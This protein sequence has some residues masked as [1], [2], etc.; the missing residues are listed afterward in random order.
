MKR[1]WAVI[2]KL[3]MQL[4][5]LRDEGSQLDS[6][7]IAGVD[8]ECAC[9][10]M[11]LLIVAGLAV[12]GCPHRLT[13]HGYLLRMTRQGLELLERMRRENV[14]AQPLRRD[15]PACDIELRVREPGAA[16]RHADPCPRPGTRAVE[17]AARAAGP[18]CARRSPRPAPRPAAGNE[19]RHRPSPPQ[20]PPPTGGRPA[21]AAARRCRR[22]GAGQ[23]VRGRG[24]HPTFTGTSVIV[25][26]PKR[27]ITFT[28]TV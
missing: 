6:D 26:L 1:E 20:G 12:G 21:A 28:A 13:R 18:G 5:A 4:E 27:S 14:S 7:A 22:T 15:E 17:R 9:C 16:G 10:D 19:A 8:S 3:L 25:S 23:F 24:R 11:R 2:G